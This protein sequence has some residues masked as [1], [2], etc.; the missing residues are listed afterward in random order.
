MVEQSRRKKKRGESVIMGLVVAGWPA[1]SSRGGERKEE[2][3][4]LVVAPLLQRRWSGSATEG[5][6]Y[7]RDKREY[8]RDLGLFW[9]FAAHI[10]DLEWGFE[11]VFG[12]GSLP[13]KQKWKPICLNRLLLVTG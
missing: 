5:R 2:E 12:V 4:G 7:T 3:K 6:V 13:L 8:E 1:W 9:V 11:F 10:A